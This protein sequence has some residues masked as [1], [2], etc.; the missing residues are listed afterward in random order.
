MEI[1]QETGFVH[2]L[3]VVGQKDNIFFKRIGSEYM[4]STDF[5]NAESASHELKLV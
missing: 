5:E 1:C 2:G 4:K 3:L